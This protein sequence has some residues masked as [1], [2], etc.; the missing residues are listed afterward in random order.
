MPDKKSK[1]DR[2]CERQCNSLFVPGFKAKFGKKEDK[3]C[4]DKDNKDRSCMACS[5][6]CLMQ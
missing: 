3:S 5:T 4:F 1:D 2:D 6:T